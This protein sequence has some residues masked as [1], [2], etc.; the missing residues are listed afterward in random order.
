LFADFYWRPI[1]NLTVTPGFKFVDFKRDVNAVNENVAGAP[2]KNEPLVAT[3]TYSSPL[4]FLTA[5]Y[6]IMPY[7][8]VYGQFATSFLIPELSDL[9]TSAVSLQD[10]QSETT[11]NYQLGTVY[12]R[13]NLT[14]D[15]DVYLIDAN[16]LQ[17]QCSVPDPTLP[18]GVGAGYCNFGKA[19]FDGVEGEIAYALPL[20]VT[21]FANGSYNEAIQTSGP[22]AGEYGPAPA[23]GDRLPNAPLWTDAL[24]AIYDKDHWKGSLTFK[25]V[26]SM[27]V[28]G[29]LVS[30]TMYTLPGYYTL[31]G[32]LG[33]AF[34]HFEV[35][36]Q[37][38][39]LLD[40]RA[41]TNF[42]PGSTSYELYNPYDNTGIYTFQAGRQ[43]L[44]TVE[45][46]Y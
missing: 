35:K 6:K 38:F 5:N 14:G 39:N 22:G 44:L 21:L 13:G 41:V 20:G 33:Y 18:T 42:T 23:A 43:I 29:G 28:Y 12:T 19:R 11:V 27:V 46:K 16:N 3:N 37:V 34:P 24:G 4:Y 7:W 10:L 2:T 1:A 9:Y 36:L 15:A 8:A 32:S 30:T 31:D 25:Q 45:G 40:R 17:A 26:G